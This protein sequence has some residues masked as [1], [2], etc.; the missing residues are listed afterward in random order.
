ML[1]AAEASMSVIEHTRRRFLEVGAG[2]VGGLLGAGAGLVQPERALTQSVLTDVIAGELRIFAGGFVPVG[3]LACHGQ[4]L[5]V[6]DQPALTRAI[7]RTFGAGGKD[8]VRVPDLR[9]RA[10]VG[11]GEPPGGPLHG[12]G[13]EGNALAVSAA[14]NDPST[15][16]LTCLIAAHEEPYG[17][18]IG[19][20]RAFSFP[21]APAGW[22]ICDGRTL[23]AARHPELFT[24][25]GTRFGGEAPSF[26]LPDLR[27]ATP[28]SHG[29]GPGLP[30]TPI[31]QHHA[32][33]A[34]TGPSRHVRLHVTYCIALTGNYPIGSD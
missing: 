8:H 7:G 26:S 6:S 17:P 11:S 22:T 20:V 15:L 24:I 12:I 18:L 13:Q 29:H 14:N 21:F 3:W 5:A 25:I 27:S 1:G 33:L 9:D 19:E 16:A 2:A 4:Q 30:P 34:P 28:L 23:Q 10:L 31:G 32:D